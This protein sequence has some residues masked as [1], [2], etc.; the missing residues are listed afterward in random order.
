M[1]SGQQIEWHDLDKRRFYVIGPSMFAC[2]RGIL[3]PINLVKVRLFMQDGNS[4]YSGTLDAFRKILQREGIQG[5]YRGF[6]VSLFGIASAQLYITSYE[7]F[8]SRL[9]GYSSEV[10]GLIA[11][12]CATI[13][14]Q[15]LTVPV[16]IVSQHMMMDGQVKMNKPSAKSSQYILV[17]NTDY[18][19]P[20]KTP[21]VRS[22]YH[23]VKEILRTEGINGLHKGYS[24]SLLT[25]APN[26][27]LFWGMYS[28]LYRRGMEASL[29]DSVPIPLLQ[30]CCGVV[31]GMTSSCLTNPLDVLRTRYQVCTHTTILLSVDT[32]FDTIHA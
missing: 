6:T 7:V 13:A 10:K 1:E 2:V 14:G 11:G 24:V 21:V 30:A 32:C 17:K 18:V 9:H 12:T 28:M 27:A 23:I 5:L 16:D 26:S 4:I 22:A 25:Y 8:R 31:G 20:R 15:L 19:L 3:Y 29:G